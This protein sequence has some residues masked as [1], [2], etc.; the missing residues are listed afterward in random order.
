M[1]AMRRLDE[2][3]ATVLSR[4]KLAKKGVDVEAILNELWILEG[5]RHRNVLRLVEYFRG[6]TKFALVLQRYGAS[7]MERRTCCAR[8]EASLR[9]VALDLLQAL[10]YLQSQHVVHRNVTLGGIVMIG[11]KVTQ[12]VALTEFGNA[13]RVLP[14]AT[15]LPCSLDAKTCTARDP[16]YAAPEVED[17]ASA[18]WTCK[19]DVFAAGLCLHQLADP[20]AKALHH[21]AAESLDSAEHGEPKL[22]LPEVCWESDFVEV[23]PCAANRSASSID[24]GCMWRAGDAAP[25]CEHSQS[26][27]EFAEVWPHEAQPWYHMDIQEPQEAVIALL[28]MG[29]AEALCL[30][31][32]AVSRDGAAWTSLTWSPA[33]CPPEPAFPPAS[34]RAPPLGP[35]SGATTPSAGQRSWDKVLRRKTVRSRTTSDALPPSHPLGSPRSL[36]S[37]PPTQPG[38]DQGE[39]R[40]DLGLGLGPRPGFGS[41]PDLQGLAGGRTAEVTVPGSSSASAFIRPGALAGLD[42]QYTSSY[43]GTGGPE[44]RGLSRPSSS[45]YLSDGSSTCSDATS[46]T[47]AVPSVPDEHAPQRGK[48][49]MNAK[50]ARLR[51]SVASFFVRSAPAPGRAKRLRSARGPAAAAAVTEVRCFSFPQQLRLRFA[52]LRWSHVASKAVRVALSAAADGGVAPE[53]WEAG[54]TRRPRWVPASAAARQVDGRLDKSAWCP[55]TAIKMSDI[56]VKMSSSAPEGKPWDKAAEPAAPVVR[57]S[58]RGGFR[59]WSLAWAEQSDTGMPDWYAVDLGSVQSVRGLVTQG[60]ESEPWWVT[61]YTVQVATEE[62]AWELV[63]PADVGHPFLRA[64]GAADDLFEGNVDGDS[65]VHGM[66][67]RRYIARF[68]RVTPRDWRGRA[69]L[70]VGVLITPGRFNL[71]PEAPNEFPGPGCRQFIGRL[72]CP[73]LE[74]RYDPVQALDDPFLTATTGTAAFSSVLSR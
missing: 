45:A 65:R 13:I 56:C 70:R 40:Q 68:L 35:G 19:A 38:H 9:T 22:W 4:L 47:S 41:N 74:E 37:R 48:A 69:A 8:D 57:D 60:H 6:P 30:V 1:A 25:G 16:F 24:H 50:D 61:S 43:S 73:G 72:T 49:G 51:E 3:H 12:G 46:V 55:S 11:E 2:E 32:V 66:F 17:T 67:D 44:D 7:L 53:Q 18:C 28:L 64:G 23:N 34:P 21:Q 42:L 14:G 54:G 39:R 15:E 36:V 5:L 33:A 62:G 71:V 58:D 29:S 10:A 59:T 63:R 27:V 26:P 20:E 31:E 52:R